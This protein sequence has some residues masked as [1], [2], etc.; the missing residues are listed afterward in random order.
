MAEASTPLNFQE[1]ADATPSLDT[2]STT[3]PA[4]MSK[5]QSIDF[6]KKVAG[7]IRCDD[8][9][10]FQLACCVAQKG[11]SAKNAQG[12]LSHTKSLEIK[13]LLYLN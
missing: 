11:G 9:T 2:P 4:L 12:N 1:F 10:A 6:V 3:P 7:D 5:E 8:P 13:R